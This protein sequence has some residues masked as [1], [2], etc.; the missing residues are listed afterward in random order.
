MKK[1]NVDFA[2]RVWGQ[3]QKE[4]PENISI[5]Q[6]LIDINHQKEQYLH[7][8]KDKKPISI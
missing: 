8:Q 3:Y 5:Q 1:E 6:F 4:Q 7:F 2:L